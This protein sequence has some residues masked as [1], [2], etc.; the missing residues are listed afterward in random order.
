MMSRSKHIAFLDTNTP[1]GWEAETVGSKKVGATEVTAARQ[2]LALRDIFN[3]EVS[4]IQRL[5]KTS[6]DLSG[7][8]YLNYNSAREYLSPNY[9]IM[10]KSL[11]HEDVDY[12][13]DA[14][15]GSKL[16]W[17]NKM[18]LPYTQGSYKG[19]EGVLER[20]DGFVHNS[21]YTLNEYS[22]YIP[23]GKPNTYIYN[24]V[25][26]Y[27]ILDKNRDL[28]RLMYASHASKGL[29]KT[30]DMF[31]R[32]KAKLPKLNFAACSAYDNISDS[33]YVE[34]LGKLS[35]PDLYSELSGS[36]CLF[37]LQGP[38]ER[39]A[40]ESFGV[41]FVD[42]MMNGTPIITNNLGA[43][44]EIAGKCKDNLILEYDEP[45]ESQ[46]ARILDKITGLQNEF[47]SIECPSCFS[48]GSTT[49]AWN[50]FLCNI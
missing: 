35:I 50:D 7:I 4:Y 46:Q 19:F 14:F 12:V 44:S 47:P 6:C 42:A 32:L 2:G 39:F 3:Y 17:W 33:E 28:N 15:P 13:R 26:D 40:G 8:K 36:L 23:N 34:N 9:I 27:S 24:N 21:A 29:E 20:L 31:K 22:P 5:R 10:L 49:N 11:W 16:I 45:A 37:F 41:V 30:V 38:K 48:V 1:G 18:D 25:E 43:A